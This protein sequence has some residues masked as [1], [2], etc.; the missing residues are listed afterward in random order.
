[1][2]VQMA[3]VYL[4]LLFFLV[5]VG[6]GLWVSRSGAPYPVLLFNFHKLAALAGVV[7]AA[8]RIGSGAVLEH[9]SGWIAAAVVVMGVCV[10]VLFATGA[11]MNIK[12]EGSGLVLFLHRAGPVIITLCLAGILLSVSVAF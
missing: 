11:V 1:M 6:S 5:A 2:T 10:L 7:L 3:P 4:P 12:A 8:V 9:P